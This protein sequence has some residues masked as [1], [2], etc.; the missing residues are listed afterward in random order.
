MLSSGRF[1]MDTLF[2]Q[3]FQAILNLFGCVA[4]IC[5][6]AV[7]SFQHS[8][9]SAAFFTLPARKDAVVP[10]MGG[11]A[12]NLVSLEKWIPLIQDLFDE[13]L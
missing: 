4:A 8:D 7:Q 13:E 5:G 9:D 11:M 10:D 12:G 2:C 3:S 1:L 6:G